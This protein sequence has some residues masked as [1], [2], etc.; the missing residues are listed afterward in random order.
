MVLEIQ[1]QSLVLFTI[2]N[3]TTTAIITIAAYNSTIFAVSLL[4]L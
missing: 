4:Q 1:L 3:S 2:L